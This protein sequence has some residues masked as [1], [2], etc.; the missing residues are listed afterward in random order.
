MFSVDNT[1][2]IFGK[3]TSST[4]KIISMHMQPI[5]LPHNEIAE[6]RV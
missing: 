4:G 1:I 5:I 2:S 6:I 3:Q